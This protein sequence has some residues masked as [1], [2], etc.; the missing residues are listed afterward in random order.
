M[1]RPGQ[2]LRV[3]EGLGSK[4][5]RQLAHGGTVVSLTHWTPLLPGHIPGA[6]LCD[7]LSRSQRHKAARR[8]MP[9]KHSSDTIGNRT[10]DNPACRGMPQPSALPRALHAPRI[11]NSAD[12]IVV[13]LS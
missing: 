3:P 5:S 11:Y 6:H 9:M 2:A 8:I 10:R 4:I 12:K 7:R 1:Y 13:L